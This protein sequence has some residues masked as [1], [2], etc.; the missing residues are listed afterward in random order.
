MM[1]RETFFTVAVELQ[2]ARFS[3]Y[4]TVADFAPTPDANDA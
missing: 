4:P 2:S 3:P 1:Q